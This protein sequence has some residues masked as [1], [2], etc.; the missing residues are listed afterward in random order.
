[1][2]IS[3]DLEDW[4]NNTILDDELN[5][6]FDLNDDEFLINDFIQWPIK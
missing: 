1:M 3:Q 2:E 5:G 4:H 6:L